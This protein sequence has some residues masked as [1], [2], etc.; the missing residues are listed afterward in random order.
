M[1]RYDH[2]LLDAD[3]TLFDF[4]R[5]EHEALKRS[6]T[7]RDCPFTTEVEALYLS[8]N[9]AL[10]ADFDQG[11]GTQVWLTVERFRR[12]NAALGLQNDPEEFNRD[13][14]TYLGQCAVLLPGALELCKALHEA[15]C[16]LSIATNGVARVQ[17]ARLEGS[18]LRPYISH[19]FISEELGAQKPLPGFFQPMLTALNITDKSRCLMVGDNLN[20]DIRGGRDAGLDTVWYDPHALPL[21]GDIRPTFTV[22]DYDQLKDLILT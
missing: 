22:T 15:G 2:I 8:I 13:Y 3:N 19:L 12:F 21:T 4:D 14:L 1:R 18:P 7:E 20:S 11:L 16:V 9:R 17:H 10:W 6:V 5:A